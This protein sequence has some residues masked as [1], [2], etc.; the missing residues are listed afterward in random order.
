MIQTINHQR[1]VGGWLYVRYA[2]MKKLLRLFLLVIV[3]SACSFESDQHLEWHFV[4]CQPSSSGQWLSFDRANAPFFETHKRTIRV[5]VAT[6]RVVEA[7]D[8]GVTAFSDCTVYDADNWSCTDGNNMLH[9]EQGRMPPYCGGIL[10]FLGVDTPQRI[11]LFFL[12]DK[13]ADRLCSIH[14]DTFNL[15]RNNR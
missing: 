7:G 4:A 9:V 2:Q 15:M 1:L 5:S 12:G 14:D 6:Q 8:L 3:I 11:R 13:E 10:C